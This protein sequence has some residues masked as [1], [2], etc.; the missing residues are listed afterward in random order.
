MSKEVNEKACFLDMPNGL[1]K[2]IDYPQQFVRAANQG[3]NPC[4]YAAEKVDAAK[5]MKMAL[6]K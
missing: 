3:K 4:N 5:V 1:S 2:E 6:G